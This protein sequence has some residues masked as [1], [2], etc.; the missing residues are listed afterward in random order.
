MHL[1]TYQK[2]GPEQALTDVSSYSFNFWH[3]KSDDKTPYITFKMLQEHEVLS[4]E[5]VDRQDCCSERFR[6]VEVRVGPTKSFYDAQSCGTKSF[7]G[8]TTYM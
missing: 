6:N 7:S 8:R 3:S 1:D 5:I 2:W 4:I